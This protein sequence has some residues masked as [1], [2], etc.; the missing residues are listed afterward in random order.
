MSINTGEPTKDTEINNEVADGNDN[1][2]PTFNAALR[3][4][5]ERVGTNLVVSRIEIHEGFVRD[6]ALLWP[7]LHKRLEGIHRMAGDCDFFF[8]ARVFDFF[9]VA[10]VLFL[11][12]VLLG[13][14][15]QNLV[16]GWVK[17]R[18]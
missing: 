16:L 18:F 12:F 9:F 1:Y 11:G 13:I 6:P 2:V 15:R 14:V 3:R 17:S 8:V 7:Q 4:S 10:R 5:H